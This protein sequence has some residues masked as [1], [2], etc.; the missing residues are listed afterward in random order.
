[1]FRLLE[2]LEPAARAIGAVNTVINRDGELVGDNTD[3]RGFLADL[4]AQFLDAAWKD[5]PALVLGA[6][7]AARAVAFAL[8]EAGLPAVTIANRTATK[9]EALA[10]E[11]LPATGRATDLAPGNLDAAAAKA[12]LIVNT[13]SMGLADETIP[14]LDLARASAEAAVYDLIYNPPETPLLAQARQRGLAAAN[15]LGML[16]RQGA[17]SYELWTGQAPPVAPV[18]EALKPAFDD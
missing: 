11:L 1:V 7:G 6:G 17:I 18:I 10:A 5:R 3:A 16:V 2:H 4:E 15:G 12:G 14:G 13:T 8:G 9:A